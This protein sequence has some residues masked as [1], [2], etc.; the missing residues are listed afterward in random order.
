MRRR[1]PTAQNAARGLERPV[2][3]PLSEI[4]HARIE[5]RVLEALHGGAARAP[6][7]ASARRRWGRW[8]VGIAAVS[9]A[10]TIVL[11]V[12]R[13]D[14]P[15]VAEP[16]AGAAAS[17]DRG[18]LVPQRVA[19]GA[20]PSS[21]SF[22]DAELALAPWTTALLVG[23]AASGPLVVI[24]RGGAEFE[25]APRGPRPPLVVTAGAVR[26]T[27]VGTR[28]TVTREDDAAT[29]AV[30]HG[31]VDVLYRGA[32]ARV[33]AGE[34][35]RP[36]D[37][38][39]GAAPAAAP[40]QPVAPPLPTTAPPPSQPDAAPPTSARPR[41]ERFDAALAL[42][43]SQPTRALAEYRALARG[44]D[45]WAANACFAAARLLHERGELAAARRQAVT[46]TRRFPRGPNARDAA[47]L[48][49]SIDQATASADRPSA[50]P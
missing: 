6:A 39:V 42:E 24:D 7:P 15:P 22:A 21:V 14:A 8:A 2:V 29:V 26:V 1:R 27:V 19:T 30:A 49:K 18:G 20:S 45:A 38:S 4:E 34:R 12:R 13:G 10:A 35:W 17:S 43:A 16:P 41:A 9:A 36:P 31:A 46:Y 25:V 32:T 40:G 5:R 44:A 50:S 37:A 23:D 48:I 3:E 28:F 47:D 11:V 33:G